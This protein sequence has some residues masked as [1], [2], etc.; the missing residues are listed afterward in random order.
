[1]PLL[2]LA[3]GLMLDALFGR[4]PAERVRPYYLVAMLAVAAW[5]VLDGAWQWVSDLPPLPTPA[6]RSAWLGAHL[7]GFAAVDWLNHE[8][9]GYRLYQLEHERLAYFADGGWLG[10][11]FGPYRASRVRDRLGNAGA[12]AAELDAMGANFLLLPR[13]A[14]LPSTAA[15]AE[16]FERRFAD[17]DAVVYA[18][19]PRP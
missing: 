4:R 3:H 6:A 9:P 1:L 12:L 5:G 13:A 10:D 18:V 19:R 8:A 11:A 15:F 7:P 2:A 14:Q 17:D 16:R